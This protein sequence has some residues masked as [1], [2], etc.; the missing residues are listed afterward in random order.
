MLENP[1][2]CSI[3]AKMTAEG[4]QETSVCWCQRQRQRHRGGGVKAVPFAMT[5]RFE[6]RA[7]P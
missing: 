4:G 3:E 1:Q 2:I 6:A 5:R 7:R